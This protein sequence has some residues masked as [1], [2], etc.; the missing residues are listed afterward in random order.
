M[1]VL[2]RSTLAAWINPSDVSAYR[3]LVAKGA[4]W[5]RGYG[6]NL[7]NGKLNFIK[8]GIGDVTSSV[9]ISAGAWQHV[10]ITW[11]AATSEVKFYLNGALAQTVINASVVN[12]PL[13]SDN[14]L[15]GLWLN[16]GSYFAGA[17]DELRVY[18][19][20]LSAADLSALYNI[21]SPPDTTPP[22]IGRASCRERV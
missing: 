20:V 7:I 10:A 18:N 21:S 4:F 2:F 9:A 17:M 15:V 13:D 12:A 16:G 3:T 6:M 11:N 22:K 1:R 14:L 19:R 8:V 5:Q